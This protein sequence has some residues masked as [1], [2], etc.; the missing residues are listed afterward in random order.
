MGSDRMTD[1]YMGGSD[2]PTDWLWLVALS[3]DPN[4]SDPD[5]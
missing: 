4:R 2:V 1:P 5:Q 3:N